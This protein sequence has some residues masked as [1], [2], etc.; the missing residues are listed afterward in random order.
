MFARI[1]IGLLSMLTLSWAQ[2]LQIFE[3]KEVTVE[4]NE[5]ASAQ[6]IR[7]TSRLYP[8]RSVTAMDIQRGIRRLWD[9][10]FFGDVQIYMD[11]ESD[12]GLVLRIAVVEYPSLEEVV[13]EGNKKIGKNKILEAIEIKSPQILSEYAVSEVVRK[14]K[15]L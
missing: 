15:K 2:Q 8:G 3:L 11:E 10:G 6:V 4:G 1:L 7:S 9:L 13:L 14:V 5:R 12:S